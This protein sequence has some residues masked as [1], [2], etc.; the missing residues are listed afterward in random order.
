MVYYEAYENEKNARVR[1]QKLKHDGNA[2]R[3]LKKRVGLSQGDKS[4]AGFTLM[5]L[6]VVLGL[7]AILLGAGVPITLGMY[8]QYSFHSERD[9]LVSIIAKARTQALSNVN[10]APHGL[11][12]A[13]GNY[14]IFEGADYASRVQSLDEIIPA[15]PTI[16]FTGSTS[17]ITFAQLT[18]DAT[19]AGTL[20]MTSGNR[21]ADIIVNNEGRID[22]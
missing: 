3:E 8:R 11:A 14:I 6:L 4:G 17:E 19:G 20:T 1:E 9:M 22:W 15:N 7:F 12:I 18:A 2:M 10:E 21:T 16:T 5:E 13:G